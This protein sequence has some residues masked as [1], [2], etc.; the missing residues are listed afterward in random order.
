MKHDDEKVTSVGE[1]LEL[2]RSRREAGTHQWFRGHADKEWKLV[3][4][5]G[6]TSD[7]QQAELTVIKQFKQNALQFLDGRP[8][9]EWDWLFL[10]QHHG[11]P[12]RLLDWTESPLTALYFATSSQNHKDADA[13]V[14][15]LDPSKLNANANYRPSFSTELP[16]LGV[17]ERLNEYLPE[18][19][20]QERSSDYPPMAAM[21]VRESARITAQLG[22]F[23]IVHRQMTPIEEVS[24]GDAVWR[25]IVPAAKKG[26]LLEELR[27]LSI[28]Q[29]TLFPELASVASMAKEVSK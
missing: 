4:T 5:V 18:K 13:A 20:T 1:V 11:A 26:S 10:M 16:F 17:D 2:L 6:R 12:T 15:C 27:L 3:P 22:T 7:L 28:N 24:D 21:C 23:T 8:A 9:D 19:V 14:W 25:M 29:L